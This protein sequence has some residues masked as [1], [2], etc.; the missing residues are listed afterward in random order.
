MAGFRENEKQHF[1]LQSIQDVV[2]L[3]RDQLTGSD[4]PN[5]PLLS[6]VLGAIENVLTV[7]R[8][9]PGEIDHSKTLEPIFPV[10][11]LETVEALYEKFVTHVKRSIDLTKFCGEVATRELVKL[12]SDVI[13]SS[14]MR[15]FYKDKA[16]LQSLYSFLTGNK[17]DCFGVAFGVVAAFQV[18][19]YKDVH[20]ALSEDHAWVTFGQDLLETAE[21]TW[22]GKG[23]ED[24]RGQPIT[25]GVSEKSWLYLNDQPVLCTRQMEV[26][27]I[28]SGINPSISAT[29]DSLEMGSLQQELLWL[30]YD[31][32][33]LSRYPMALGNLGDLEE[34]SPTPERP[35]PIDLFNEAI[36][37]ALE[38]YNN[39]HVY[40]YTYL[41]GY[42]YRK[43][44][45]KKALQA[46]ADAA[47]TVRNYNYNRED[48]EIYKEFLE[49]A[50]DL[51]P[52]MMKIV[53][54]DN[55]ARIH[56]T[57]LLY[58][59][60]C[61]ANFLRFYD[62]ICEWEEGSPTP[63]LHITWA[64]QLVFSLSKFDLS[65]REHIEVKGE[66]L[67]DD[68][69][70]EEEEMEEEVNGRR[71]E[72]GEDK[73]MDD[74]EPSSSH[75]PGRRGRR[76]KINIEPE[77]NI[78]DIKVNGKSNED[79][80]KSAIED[81]VNK[82]GEEGQSDTTNPNIAALAQACSESI[83]NP[84][85][86]LGGGDPFTTATSTTTVASST[87]SAD[88][89][90]DMHDFL[91]SKS[92]G[93]PF[94]G[95]TMDSVLKAESPSDMIMFR[96]RPSSSTTR[97]PTPVSEAAQTSTPVNTTPCNTCSLPSLLLGPPTLVCLRSEKMKG[98]KKIFSS[99]KLNASAIKLQLTAQSQVH[100]KHSKRSTDSELA[101]HRK[102]SRR[103]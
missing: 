61:Y 31:M 84:E 92:N 51:I 26:A 23:N 15:S 33:H 16:H 53:A 40:P 93:S 83:L 95:M 90:I 47:D 45:H 43:G 79:Q 49:I 9:L 56:H 81:L 25:M 82:V 41:G 48:E 58:D 5:L 76:P 10:I 80:I 39:Q 52:H 14:L 34:I 99:A 44:H 11:E 100:F 74:T 62:G 86:L 67:E 96:K 97:T 1:P 70:S 29:V 12:V 32:D 7:N 46:W 69:S 77:G 6:I 13:W 4:E 91:S 64:K 21:V 98:L 22:H 30:L 63:V 8:S 94:M 42:L 103:E 75:R 72:E 24:K 66:G 73:V 87:T 101:T 57:S 85:Y 60:D 19:G 28:V 2:D 27:S 88:A 78:S 59:P 71:G 38:H 18:L 68:S 3:F 35:Q 36:Q 50:N 89:R 65:V 37:S 55:A 17:L 20:L 54:S 102:R